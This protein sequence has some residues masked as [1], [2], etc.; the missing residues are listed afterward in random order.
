MQKVLALSYGLSNWQVPT[1]AA[2]IPEVAGQ[3]GDAAQAT[4]YISS[5]IMAA[6]IAFLI[7]GANSDL[8]GRRWFLVG[9]DVF[10]FVGSILCA[11]ANNNKQMIAGW[12]IFGFGAGNAQLAAFALPELLPNKHRHI[13]VIIADLGTFFSLIVGPVVARFAIRHGQ[14]WRWLLYA[15]AIGSVVS[16]VLLYL[17]YFPPRHPRGVRLIF[18]KS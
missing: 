8:F 1:I 17:L 12:A 11:T 10:L 16:G 18:S 6:A 3:M 13:G 9:A 14:A 2:I 4:W 15:P 7:C 5:Y